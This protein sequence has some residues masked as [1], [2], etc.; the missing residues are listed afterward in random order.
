[1]KTT[2][3]KV[4]LAVCIG[5]IVTLFT[6]C[7]REPY[8]KIYYHNVN[9]EG[10]VY[11]QDEPVANVIISISSHFKSQGWATR[12]PIH[13]DFTSDANG[14]F[15]ARFIKKVG[16]EN[17]ISYSVAI[18]NDTIHYNSVL[19]GRI[20]ISPT[21]LR[22]AKENIQLGKLNLTRTTL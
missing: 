7:D 10:Y 22:N 5:F 12:P 6:A 4:I 2:I 14:Y 17:A 15:C 1:M 21:D 19:N 20:V 13:E 9:A 11:Y 3:N 16:S 8:D 18:G